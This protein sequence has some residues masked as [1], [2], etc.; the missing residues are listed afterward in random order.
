MFYLNTAY[1]K[2]RIWK[3]VYNA[4]YLNSKNN[5]NE[6]QYIFKDYK[7]NKTV[8]FVSIL[9]NHNT[10]FVWERAFLLLPNYSNCFIF[11]YD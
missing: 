5:K 9:F 8:L 2:K 1:V 6:L 3:V 7:N 4:I 11:I 10:N